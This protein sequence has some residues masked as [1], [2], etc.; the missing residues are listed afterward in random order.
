MGKRRRPFRHESKPE[1]AKNSEGAWFRPGLDWIH[2][3]PA[4]LCVVPERATQ[5]NVGPNARKRQG[6][7]WTDV[8][9]SECSTCVGQANPPSAA[10]DRPY[11]DDSTRD[12]RARPS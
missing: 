8:A 1:V 4:V 7:R 6:M 11:S 2:G 5:E 10:R 9:N 3:V 12:R